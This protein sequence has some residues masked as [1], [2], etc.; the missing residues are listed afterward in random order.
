MITKMVGKVGGVALVCALVGIGCGPN[1]LVEIDRLSGSTNQLSQQA[2]DLTQTDGDLAQRIDTA[3]QNV[4]DL[5][6]RVETLAAD[7]QAQIDR[8]AP[9]SIKGDRGDPGE[10]G[11]D[12]QDLSG[13]LIRA[14]VGAAGAIRAGAASVG[15]VDH[16][17]LSGKYILTFRIPTTFDTTG[18]SASSFPTIVTPEAIVPAP[19]QGPN[20]ILLAAVEALELEPTT[21]TL[22]LQVHIRQLPTLLYWDAGFSIV[23]FQP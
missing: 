19:G 20:Q 21:N 1:P 5:S 2:D 13:V 16:V 12:G 10:V 4:V 22:R 6:G 17:A 14:H 3:S 11:K 18:L 7:L 15:S 23:V 8:P 9:V